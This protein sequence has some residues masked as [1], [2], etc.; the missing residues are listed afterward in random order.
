MTCA[1]PPHPSPTRGEGGA[2]AP[3]QHHVSP[4]PD[5]DPAD[6]VRREATSR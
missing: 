3:A 1:P 6:P 2:P 4:I 5:V